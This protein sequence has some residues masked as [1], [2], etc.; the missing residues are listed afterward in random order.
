[1]RA[2]AHRKLTAIV[3]FS[4][5]TSSRRVFGGN[6]LPFDTAKLISKSTGMIKFDL[7][8][9]VERAL[10]SLRLVFYPPFVLGRQRRLA[11]GFVQLR[12]RFVFGAVYSLVLCLVARVGVINGTGN[13]VLIY[14]VPGDCFKCAKSTKEPSDGEKYLCVCVYVCVTRNDE[15]LDHI[16][17]H[18]ESSRA[19]TLG[20]GLPFTCD[21]QQW[22]GGAEGRSPMSCWIWFAGNFGDSDEK[23]PF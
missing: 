9:S 23:R 21:G 20:V 11:A 18:H 13:E 19:A 14:W 1:M 3:A 15:Y 6:L 10:I 22:G 2:L 17:N 8:F 7:E 4:H 5:Q 12:W 16:I